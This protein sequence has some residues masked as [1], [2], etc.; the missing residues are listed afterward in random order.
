MAWHYAT[1][2]ICKEATDDRGFCGCEP[3]FSLDAVPQ[4]KIRG[5]ARV[6]Y[7]QL[8]AFYKA[9]YQVPGNREKAEAW[10]KEYRRRKAEGIRPVIPS[11]EEIRV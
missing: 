3:P 5:I 4:E 11:L 2:P 6:L 7:P 8:D 1:C 9:F 10:K